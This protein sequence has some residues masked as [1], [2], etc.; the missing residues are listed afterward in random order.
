M[1]IL[2]ALALVAGLTLAAMVLW[3]RRTRSGSRR[4]TLGLFGFNVVLG[5]VFVGALLLAAQLLTDPVHAAPASETAS[6][7]R[8]AAFYAAAIATGLA[9]IGAG[10]AVGL[11]GA[12]ALGSVTERPDLFGRSLV[13]VGL[14]EGIAIY[15]VIVAILVLGRV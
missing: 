8:S 9:A 14:A 10:I 5:L 3:S 15:G 2:V 12:A 13:Y 1:P 11:T 4:L 7:D 6:T